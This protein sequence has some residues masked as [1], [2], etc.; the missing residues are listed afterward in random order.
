MIRF[1]IKPTEKVGQVIRL[2]ITLNFPS[3]LFDPTAYLNTLTPTPVTSFLTANYR[4][5]ASS[6][7][8][9]PRKNKL[10]TEMEDNLRRRL[11]LKQQVDFEEIFKRIVDDKKELCDKSCPKVDLKKREERKDGSA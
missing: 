9:R 3:Q 4:A 8:F 7:V 2:T 5:R 6:K 1:H 10:L 11:S